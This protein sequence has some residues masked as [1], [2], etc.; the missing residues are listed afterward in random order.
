MRPKILIVYNKSETSLLLRKMLDPEGYETLTAGSGRRALEMC[1]RDAPDLVLLA[2]KTR[3]IEGLEVCRQL[4]KGRTTGHIPIILYSAQKE[5]GHRMLAYGAG[6]DD[7]LLEP[8]EITEVKAKVAAHLKRLVAGASQA[9]LTIL[10]ETNVTKDRL[11]WLFSR[12]NHLL[13]DVLT[14]RGYKETIAAALGGA[15]EMTGSDW[16]S[17]AIHDAR[18]GRLSYDHFAGIDPAPAPFAWLFRLK[19]RLRSPNDPCPSLQTITRQKGAWLFL[20][21]GEQKPSLAFL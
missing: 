16:A 9:H 6:V 19:T 18:R 11:L 17:L 13:S 14:T 12:V 8:F 10:H 4:K 2:S 3:D 1:V 20:N 21:Q 7:T 15:L 5:A